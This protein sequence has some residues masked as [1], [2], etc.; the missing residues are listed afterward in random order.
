MH[1]G[2]AAATLVL[3]V[4]HMVALALDTYAG[5]GWTGTFVPG[6]SAY[7]P[8]AVGLGTIGLYVGVLTGGSVLLAGRLLGRHWLPVHR[9]A[10][11]AFVLVWCHGVLAGS[12][13]VQLR[14]L[15]LVTGVGL[16]ALAISRRAMQA[17]LAA[18]EE[19]TP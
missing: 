14:A 11:A 8:L 17:P 13:T 9:L 16:A 3:V 10:S 5:V 19:P 1:A 7:R 6:E 4:G 2:S 18:S 15:Y 12:D